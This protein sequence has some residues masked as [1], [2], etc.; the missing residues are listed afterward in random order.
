M[1]FFKFAA[2]ARVEDIQTISHSNVDHNC[3]SFEIHR[4]RRDA[5]EFHHVDREDKF[6]TFSAKYLFPKNIYPTFVEKVPNLS[7]LSMHLFCLF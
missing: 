2:P 3:I 5:V 4:V 1:G 6:G 7:S